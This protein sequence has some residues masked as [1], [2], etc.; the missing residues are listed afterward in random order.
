MRLYDGA[1]VAHVNQEMAD[2][3]L[4]AG[5]ADG[6]RRGPRH[7]LRLRQGISI[8]QTESGWEIVE[9]LRQ[10]YGDKRAAGYLAHKDRQSERLRFDPP[11][12][13]ERQLSGVQTIGQASG[14]GESVHIVDRNS[15]GVRTK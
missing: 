2:K 14:S 1:L 5:I 8:P 6:I 15:Q 12:P 10:W 13:K 7:Y 3:L 11:S 4:D 9:S